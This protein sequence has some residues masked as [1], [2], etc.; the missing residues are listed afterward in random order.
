MKLV[1]LFEAKKVEFTDDEIFDLL[2]LEHAKQNVTADKHYKIPAL[3]KAL[4]ELSQ[5]S[6]P[7]WHGVYKHEFD[8]KELEVGSTVTA[9]T[10]TSFS[11]SEEVA[12][13]FTDC[14]TLLHVKSLK[15]FNFWKW[16]VAFFK[17]QKKTDPDGYE[18]A[19]GDFM[20]NQYKD[21]KEWIIGSFKFKVVNVTQ[22]DGINI[23]EIQHVPGS[24]SQ[25]PSANT[26]PPSVAKIVSSVKDLK[27]GMKI[28]FKDDSL[29]MRT[30]TIIEVVK[31]GK[32]LKDEYGFGSFKQEAVNRIDCLVIDVGGKKILLELYSYTFPNITILG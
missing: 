17:N 6:G 11:E 15:A 3:E 12:K 26:P 29:R 9:D 20:I 18:S 21:E 19:D 13:R 8:K 10:Y 7:L 2:S 23:V 16:S 27:R 22:R 25:P 4:R 5:T 32:K 31:K 28:S 14:A 24:V 1:E 30:G